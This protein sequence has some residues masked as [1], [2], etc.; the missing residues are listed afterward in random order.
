MNAGSAPAWRTVAHFAADPLPVDWRDQ[1][2]HRLGRRPRRVGLW[3]ELA[4]FGA[5]QCLDAAGEAA[6][7]AGPACVY[8]ACAAPGARRMRAW[9][10]STPAC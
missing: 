2:A 10:S 1:L 7:P 6:L 3:T 5:R 8:R 4:M 9:R